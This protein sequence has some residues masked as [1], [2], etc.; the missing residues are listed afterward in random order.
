[1][2]LGIRMGVSLV[3]TSPNKHRH[4]VPVQSPLSI[5][6]DEWMSTIAVGDDDDDCYAREG[7]GGV[8]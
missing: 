7:G 8:K 2:G 5:S 6:P 4:R 3:Q 1:M